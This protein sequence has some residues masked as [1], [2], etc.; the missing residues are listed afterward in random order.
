MVKRQ[1]D[2][3]L[4]IFWLKNRLKCKATLRLAIFLV[5]SKKIQKKSPTLEWP[6]ILD[7]FLVQKFHSEIFWAKIPKFPCQPG[8]RDFPG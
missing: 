2:H 3:F 8:S 1:N 5:F 4:V 7:D 6:Y